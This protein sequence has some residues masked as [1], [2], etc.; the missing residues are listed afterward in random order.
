MRQIF[1]LFVTLL[2]IHL[3]FAQS[4]T[5]EFTR[6][7]V[8]E[9][10]STLS[11]KWP[12]QSNT[13]NL[14]TF[15][16]PGIDLWRRNTKAGFFFLPET[17]AAYQFFE[18][19]IG[20]KFL[21]GGGKN[22]SVGLILQAQ[23]DGT[24]A[25]IVEVNKKGYYRIQRAGN[26]TFNTEQPW[27]KLKKFNTKGE[28]FL[29]VKTYDKIYDMYVNGIFVKSFTEIELSSG[30][31]GIFI[32]ANSRSL[33]TKFSIKGDEDNQNPELEQTAP[34]DQVKALSDAIVKLRESINKKDKKIN[35][36]ENELRT[37]NARNNTDTTL[38]R[39]RAEC[40]SKNL[41][42]YAEIQ[43]LKSTRDQLTL[44]VNALEAFKKEVL[45]RENGD[46]I[47]NFANL[48]QQQKNQIKELN[49]KIKNLLVQLDEKDRQ[50]KELRD[51]LTKTRAD[52]RLL[53]QE[54][55][56]LA[57]RNY[58]KDSL[59][60]EYEKEIRRLKEILN[61]KNEFNPAQSYIKGGHG[62]M[63]KSRRNKLLRPT[64]F[65]K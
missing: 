58:E 4:V 10:F 1:V 65:K 20:F 5:K 40:E 21:K 49:D 12:M 53:E 14:F 24:A 22:A 36:L 23:K 56:N 3:N 45:G 32:G 2:A 7:L 54:N 55:E 9:D 34:V 39:L 15:M 37:A 43:D 62:N 13:D 11:E 17:E 18:A 47:T 57:S 26:S 51:E 33:F 41:E 31:I 25:L 50:K 6:T 19:T 8:E 48:S 61:N 42:Y 64:L 35:E 38:I 27:I 44:K 30:G 16:S 59:L 28:V 29:T 60:F 63:K 46:I 52:V